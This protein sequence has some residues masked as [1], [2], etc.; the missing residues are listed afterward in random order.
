MKKIESNVL[1]ISS[2]LLIIGCIQNSNAVDEEKISAS[3]SN[4]KVYEYDTGVEGDEEVLY[5]EKQANY[6]EISEI[7]RDSSTQW[8]GVYRYKPKPN[9]IGTDYVEIKTIQGSDGASPNTDINIIK[10]ELTVS[11]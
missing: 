4:T 10:I 8:R 6:F 7:V 1:I 9:Y 2:V 11:E 3:I 5:I